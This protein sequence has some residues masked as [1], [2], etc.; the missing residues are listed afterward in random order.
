M[1][2][3]IVSHYKIT[4]KIGEGG[5]GVI[6]QAE[7]TKLKRTVALKFLHN[8]WTR[9]PGARERFEQEARAAAALNNP[10]IVTI[11]AIN[12]DGDRVY[13]VMEYVQGQTLKDKIKTEAPA[14]PVPMKKEDIIDIAIQVGEGLQ[15]AHRSGI[16]HRDIKPH[17]RR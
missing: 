14:P 9:D 5:M 10:H 13:I 7:D 3:E 8:E 2:G 6:Y 11:H 17:K 15:A 4:G 1:I 16:I 12:R